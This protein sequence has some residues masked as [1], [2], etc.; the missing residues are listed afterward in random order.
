MSESVPLR[1]VYRVSPWRRAV[2]WLIFGPMLVL[3]AALVVAGETPGE[4]QAGA[5]VGCILFVAT[6]GM[7]ALIAYARLELSAEGIRLRQIG[8]NLFAPWPEVAGWRLERGREGFVTRGPITGRGA[9]NL[10]AVRGFGIYGAPIYDEEQRA[11][12]AERRWMPIEAFAWHA[13]HGRLREDVA[14]FAPSLREMP[15]PETPP[16]GAKPAMQRA[17]GLLVAVVV[18]GAAA[19]GVVLALEEPAWTDVLVVA[20]AALVSPFLTVS[21]AWS[22]R[23][24]FRTGAR[25][26]GVLFILLALVGAGWCAI[27]WSDVVERLTP[28]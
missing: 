20:L 12:M 8:M 6:V 5:W 4:R 9:A 19:L 26:V 23:N 7:H 10:A 22:A 21:A 14:Y 24:A 16:A 27:A 13:R 2:P 28:R 18:I 1:C 25:L 17:R 15:S 3:A 11:A